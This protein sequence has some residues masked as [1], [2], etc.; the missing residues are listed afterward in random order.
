MTLIKKIDVPSH[1]AAR[2]AKRRLERNLSRHSSVRP[3]A[4]IGQASTDENSG[5]QSSA[6]GQVPPPFTPNS[7][8]N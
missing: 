3:F 7:G 2:R 5:D 8:T 1:F 6:G 4:G